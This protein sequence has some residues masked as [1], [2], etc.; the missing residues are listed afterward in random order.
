MI[1]MSSF[2]LPPSFQE[3]VFPPLVCCQS[4]ALSDPL[5]Q[6]PASPPHSRW[7]ECLLH[8]NTCVAETPP[9]HR[10]PH[11]S[12]FISVAPRAERTAA[13]AAQTR[14]WLRV[15][16]CQRR[17]RNLVTRPGICGKSTL[18]MVPRWGGS[19]SASSS[20]RWKLKDFPRPVPCF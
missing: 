9:P 20:R 11:A 5:M 15:L 14:V 17:R 13:D 10:P 18:F 1:C 16:G 2:A 4:V 3:N 19:D 8:L 12:V 7:L 6:R